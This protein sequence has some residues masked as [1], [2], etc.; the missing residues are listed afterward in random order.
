M[1]MP[2]PVKM[3]MYALSAAREL[4]GGKAR[5]EDEA[6]GSGQDRIRHASS[7]NNLKRLC[8]NWV[9]LYALHISTELRL[10]AYLSTCR[11]RP[12]I[13][14]SSSQPGQECS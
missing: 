8:R 12:R 5:Y 1:C 10:D 13:T 14:K 3:R 7:I 9:F 11:I 6:E 2:M 4:S